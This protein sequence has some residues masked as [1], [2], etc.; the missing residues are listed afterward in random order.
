MD[1]Q[2][3]MVKEWSYLVADVVK[4]MR[5]KVSSQVET[6]DLIAVGNQGLLAA[7]D[8]FDPKRGV[9]F[10]SYACY[11]IRVA[12]LDYLRQTDVAGRSMREKIKSGAVP[13]L[14][15]ISLDA[16]IIGT[17]KHL[18]LRDILPDP[19]DGPE[20]EVL[21]VTECA[22]LLDRLY[23]RERATVIGRFWQELSFVEI[24]EKMGIS[25][26]AA[27]AMCCKAIQKMR[28]WSIK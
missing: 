3:R 13:D 4:A 19:H 2:E 8:H 18:T 14:I 1:R 24:G 20:V 28:R 7:I 27:Q 25:Q 10:K 11:R 5:A 9:L 12:I 17:E 22:R 21:R 26:H 15:L 6:G 16:P 23:P